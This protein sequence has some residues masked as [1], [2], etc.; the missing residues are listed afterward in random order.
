MYLTKID[1]VKTECGVRQVI[2][3]M[4]VTYVQKKFTILTLI[5]QLLTKYQFF[6]KWT[7]IS[8]INKNRNLKC[9][10]KNW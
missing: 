5:K 8:H 9:I 4:C 3:I 7:N 6:T 1:W 10:I 2:T